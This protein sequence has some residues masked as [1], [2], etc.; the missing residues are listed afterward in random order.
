MVVSDSYFQKNRLFD[1]SDPIS[2]RDNCLL[3][4]ALL[5][6]QLKHCS[7]DLATSDIHSIEESDVVIYNEMPMT[8]PR[9]GTQH[10]S[11]LL[12]FE[13][14]LIR[15]ENWN[16]DNH[17]KFDKIF[18]WH[19]D[20]VD[21][22][23]YFKINFSH[24]IPTSIHKCSHKEKLCCLI[25]GNKKVQHPLEL[26]S[27]RTEAIRWFEGYH[28]EDFDLFGMGWNEYRF[29]GSKLMRGLNRLKPL[30]HLMAEKYPSY[31]GS[32]ENKKDTLEKYKFSICFENAKDIPGYIT[33]KIF[34]CFFAGCVPVYWGANNITDHIPADCFIDMRKF[35]NYEEMYQY[36]KNMP[37]EA[38]LNF[39]NAIE[40]FILSDKIHPFSADYF[41]NTIVKELVS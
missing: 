6:E 28:P 36:M 24:E 25:A 32:V 18:T 1:L 16:L 19:D 4:F 22:K 23:K 30:T 9:L 12:L 41:A 11:Y 10:K 34:D 13:S 21:N 31:Q 40:A 2:N 5:K 29:T 37:D 39:L 27:K 7:V 35:S 33:E 14:E 17:N 20:Y 3:P 38:Y 26:Y 15:P 8:L